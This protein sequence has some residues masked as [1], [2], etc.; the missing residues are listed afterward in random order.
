MSITK[1]NHNWGS[2]E[3]WAKNEEFTGVFYSINARSSVK[4]PACK[5]CSP[6]YR[7]SSGILL[8]QQESQEDSSDGLIVT[9][10]DSMSLDKNVCYIFS[11]IRDCEVYGILPASSGEKVGKKK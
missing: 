3:V 4:I 11:A 7:V 9:A 6:T 5:S 10:G 2:I 1:E 8:L